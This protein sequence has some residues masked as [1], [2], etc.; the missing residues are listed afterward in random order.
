MQ[1]KLQCLDT[2]DA[3]PV[4]ADAAL[5]SVAALAE[6][7]LRHRAAA[8]LAASRPVAA[9]AGTKSLAHLIPP[10]ACKRT[11][12]TASKARSGGGAVASSLAAAAA[13]AEVP[14]AMARPKRAQSAKLCVPLAGADL[15]GSSKT[16][17]RLKNA[18]E[19]CELLVR[20]R[21]AL[22]R[23]GRL[24]SSGSRS[25]SVRLV[26]YLVDHKF[27]WPFRAP[28][29][30]VALGI[31]DYFK[32]IKHPMDLGTVQRKLALGE[33]SSTEAFAAD[34]RLVWS[35]SRL[36]N[37]PVTEVHQLASELSNI[38]E[39]RYKHIPKV[40]PPPPQHLPPPRRRPW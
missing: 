5:P 4:E 38:F 35:N 22:V 15:K 8:K 12:T 25:L 37:A 14:L 11:A 26:R 10:W 6:Q 7:M 33:Y 13:S 39:K 21:P 24:V 3:P 31:P 18:L 28:V 23:K 16:K 30:A 19:H 17:G 9:T 20:Y 1:H 29:D 40:R 32:V 2:A 36:Y 34:V 27:S